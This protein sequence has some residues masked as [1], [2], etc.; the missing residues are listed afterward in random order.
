MNV[1]YSL[2]E[3]GH[4]RDGRPRQKRRAGWTNCGYGRNVETIVVELLRMG[5]LVQYKGNIGRYERKGGINCFGVKWTSDLLKLWMVK[6]APITPYESS[7]LG[8][9][10]GS[11]NRGAKANKMPIKRWRETSWV[12]LYVIPVMLPIDDICSRDVSV[13]YPCPHH[14]PLRVVCLRSYSLCERIFL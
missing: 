8:A 11:G 3:L 5:S 13:N 4:I 7:G 9:S 6:R 14:K 1:L 10:P 12:P 2:Y